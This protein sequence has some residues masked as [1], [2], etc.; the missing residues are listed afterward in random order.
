MAFLPPVKRVV[1]AIVVGVSLVVAVAL[2]VVLG[3]ELYFRLPGSAVI[4]VVSS[5]Q[6][7]EI[8]GWEANAEAGLE[9]TSSQGYLDE[10]LDAAV[11]PTTR[12]RP[13]PRRS[14]THTIP[15]ARAR[16]AFQCQ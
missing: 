1:K 10:L 2:L 3:R 9:D 8:D 6:F 13:P 16:P 14:R 15:R 5:Q 11:D 12:A 7:Q 4:D